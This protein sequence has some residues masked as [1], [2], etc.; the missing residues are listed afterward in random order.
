VLLFTNDSPFSLNV[1]RVPL[2][3]ILIADGRIKNEVALVALDLYPKQFLT[4]RQL[5]DQPFQADYFTRLYDHY[6]DLA[7]GPQEFILAAELQGG[8]WNMP[9]LGAPASACIDQ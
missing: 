9:L 3:E 5:Q 1:E 7:T 4:N 2:R 6:G 8:F